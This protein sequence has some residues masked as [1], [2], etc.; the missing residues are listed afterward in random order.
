MPHFAANLSMMFTEKA[1]P[2]RFEAAARQGFSAVEIQFPYDAPRE[3]YRDWLQKAEQ[4]LVLINLPA[5]DRASGE[6]GLAALP[7]READ[8]MASL[9]TAITTAKFLDCP[10]LHAMAAVLPAGADRDEFEA[11]YVSNL[12]K[13]AEICTDEGITLLIEPINSR[14]IPG[15]F[16]QHQDH[17]LRILDQVASPSLM[18]L[19][20]IY[21]C[22][23][24]DGDLSTRLTAQMPW[25]GHIQIAGVPDRQEPDEGE[26]NYPW[27]FRLMDHLG[28]Q[29]WVGCEYRPRLETVE[30]L[31]WARPWG[32]GGWDDVLED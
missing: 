16:L 10:R 31:G 8:F 27:L 22:Q 13:A 32:I 5:G 2:D 23:I 14:D 30:G 9:K 12:R 29:G 21:H 7:G 24:M 15:Y 11:V 4:E 18:L 6:W 19:F 20:D 3:A 28:Y 1:M 17:A 25:I 26:I